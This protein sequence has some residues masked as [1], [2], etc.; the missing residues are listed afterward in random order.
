MRTLASLTILVAL[1]AC[2]G[3]DDAAVDAAPDGLDID[4]PV[5][6]MPFVP[7]TMLS[8][9]GLYS[10]IAA[11]TIAADVIE[12]MPRWQL[13]SDSAEKRRW[14]WLPP[15][16][17]IDTSNPNFWSFPVGTKMWKEFVRGTRLETRFMQKIGPTDTW[18]DWYL[19]SF[20]WNAAQT[21]AMAV[22]DGVIDDNGPND[23]PARSDC[24][25]C[26]AETRN[27][28]LVLGFQALQ[29]DYEPA[30]PAFMSLH[31]LVADG[32]LTT[33][34][35]GGSATTPYYPLPA[36]DLERAAFGYLHS[37][38]GGCHNPR[39]EVSSQTPVI[40][41]QDVTN[42]ATWENTQPYLTTVDVF[43]LTGSPGVDLVV[44]RGSPAQSAIYYRMTNNGGQ[45][46]PPV[47]RETVDPVGSEAVRAWIAALPVP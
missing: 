1:A 29:L 5:D 41:R 9:T 30:N 20:Q 16:T 15:G 3:G 47:G 22:P 38:C 21:E 7:P 35:T 10:D 11:G 45:R 46:M 43:P 40:L 39:S 42:L 19:V 4:A 6:A 28:S 12:F 13:W 17:Q 44:H 37:N 24:R 2:G 18:T 25:K 31:R 23:I 33:A 34:P 8:Q 14:V 32:R 27:P 26:H 36:G